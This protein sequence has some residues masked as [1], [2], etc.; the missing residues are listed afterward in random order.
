MAKKRERWQ[1]EAF[2]AE[3]P[4]A[5]LLSKHTATDDAAP[6]SAETSQTATVSEPCAKLVVKSARI[7]RAH[8]SGKTVTIVSFRGDPT[9]AQLISWL[10]SAKSAFGCGGTLEDDVVVL[11]GD[12]VDRVK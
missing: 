4:F 2:H 1:E 8:R 7:E 12:L 11:Q 5:A 6:K 10:K 9:H 3:N